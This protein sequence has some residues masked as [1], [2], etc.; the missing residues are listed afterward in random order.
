MI[1]QSGG[2]HKS[3]VT[4]SDISIAAVPA[5]KGNLHLMT[6][7]HRIGISN[8]TILRRILIYALIDASNVRNVRTQILRRAHF[9][10]KYWPGGNNPFAV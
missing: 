1:N 6:S 7:M 5:K 8:W 3:S 9:G 2:R 4:T 10:L